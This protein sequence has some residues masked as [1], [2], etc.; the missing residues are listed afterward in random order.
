MAKFIRTDWD[1][2]E[3][4]EVGQGTS[5]FWVNPTTGQQFAELD[6]AAE[7]I[8]NEYLATSGEINPEEIEC[9]WDLVEG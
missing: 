7:S 4:T 3:I 8:I 1:D 6:D 5:H 9:D 2:L